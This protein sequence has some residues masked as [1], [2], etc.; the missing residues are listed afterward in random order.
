[1]ANLEEKIAKIAYD[2]ERIKGAIGLPD[3][4]WK[5]PKKA[6]AAMGIGMGVDWLRKILQRADYAADAREDC[7]LKRGVHFTRIDGAWLVNTATIKPILLSG[8]M[9]LPQLPAEYGDAA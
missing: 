3:D 1:M 4:D 7:T 9:V 2:L 8:E 6:L 5:P